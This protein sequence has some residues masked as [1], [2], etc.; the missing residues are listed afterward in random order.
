MNYKNFN[1]LL[2]LENDDFIK[3][4][5]KI[6]EEDIFQELENNPTMQE[7]YQKKVLEVYKNYLDEK[8]FIKRHPFIH[9]KTLLLLLTKEQLGKLLVFQ[10]S[11]NDEFLEY[12]QYVILKAKINED[13]YEFSQRVLLNEIKRL[14]TNNQYQHLEDNIDYLKYIQYFEPMLDRKIFLFNLYVLFIKNIKLSIQINEK[15]YLEK[16]NFQEKE[17]K[18]N[19]I[20]NKLK[21]SMKI[22]EKFKQCLSFDNWNEELLEKFYKDLN[23]PFPYSNIGIIERVVEEENFQN[24]SAFLEKIWMNNDLEKELR[25]KIKKNKNMKI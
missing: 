14:E 10:G 4:I 7:K 20:N 16:F 22:I 18:I 12:Y 24:H 19:N 3:E 15:N 8:S 25:K 1:Q 21:N 23:I 13:L 9:S 11:F 2:N 5:N 17:E 6:N